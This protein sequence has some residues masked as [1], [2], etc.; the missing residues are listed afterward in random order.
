MRQPLSSRPEQPA[1]KIPMRLFI[2]NLT[3]TLFIP[4]TV[5]GYI[6]IRILYRHG[7]LV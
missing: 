3:F 5:A 4:G 1:N 7:P 6:P 2:K